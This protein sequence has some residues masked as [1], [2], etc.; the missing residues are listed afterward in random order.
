MKNSHLRMGR[1]TFTRRTRDTVTDVSVWLH[2]LIAECADDGGIGSR[3]HLVSVFG[4]DQ[5]IGAITAAVIEGMY[6]QVTLQERTCPILLGEKAVLYRASLQAQGRKRPVRHLVAISQ[7]L[8][9]TTMA[10]TKETQRTVLYDQKPGFIL[11][12]LSMRFG[13]PVLP[14]WADWFYGE[15]TNQNM[16]EHL[17]GWNCSPI[18]V[19]AGKG[20][21]LN[22]LSRGLKRKQISVSNGEEFGQS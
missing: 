17:I 12:R 15:I 13:L 8:A 6:F 16:I 1:L 4:N 19:R 2:Q 18:A 10:A 21:L 22:I 9:E 20:R 3:V 14:E 7:E 11:H 5:E